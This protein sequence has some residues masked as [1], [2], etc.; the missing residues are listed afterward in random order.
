MRL[1]LFLV[2]LPLVQGCAPHAYPPP[3][4][5][6]SNEPSTR[7]LVPEST[8]DPAVTLVSD[9]SRATLDH[10][11]MTPAEYASNTRSRQ[12]GLFITLAD[13]SPI[14]V[15][16]C[17]G[18][19]SHEALYTVSGPGIKR[20]TFFVLPRAEHVTVEAHTGSSALYA[21]GSVLVVVG[22]LALIPSIAAIAEERS[23]VYGMVGLGG[24]LGLLGGGV[25]TAYKGSTFVKVTED[26]G[27]KR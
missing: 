6:P 19:L 15:A 4:A 21:L 7:N 14:C 24:S 27:G 12:G 5:T 20:S 8:E 16:P 11:D 1:A 18:K 9:D 2:C 23:R 17:G 26:G 10:V 13:S 25:F 3:R 22:A